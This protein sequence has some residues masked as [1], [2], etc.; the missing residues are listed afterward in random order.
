MRPRCWIAK[1]C[2]QA[3]LD[4]L[5]DAVV[6]GAGRLQLIAGAAGTGKTVLLREL[7]RRAGARGLTVLTAR[8][9][10]LERDFGFGLVAQLF[11]A[12]VAGDERGDDLFVGA[13]AL[14]RPVFDAAP[15]AVGDD[16]SH[17]VLHGLYWLVVN[18][19]ETSPRSSPSTMCIGPTGPRCGSCST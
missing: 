11:D 7:C 5:I 9:G 18:L 19:A 6:A 3:R 4:A 8:G 13:A 1:R 2:C 16:V 14:A 12:L 10:E 15:D 17:S